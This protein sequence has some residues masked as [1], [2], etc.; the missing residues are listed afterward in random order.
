M[1]KDSSILVR[2]SDEE[3]HFIDE[4]ARLSKMKTSSWMRESLLLMADKVVNKTVEIMVP[5]KTGVPVEVEPVE[6]LVES[7]KVRA[8]DPAGGEVVVEPLPG[9]KVCKKS[10]LGQVPFSP[11]KGEVERVPVVQRNAR[12]HHP[13]CTCLMCAAPPSGKVDAGKTES[14][15]SAPRLAK[16][17]KMY[18]GE[19]V[20]KFGQRAYE[21]RVGDR[22]EWTFEVP[23]FE[24]MP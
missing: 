24:G 7:A 5:A 4:A 1:G 13:A 2:V 21:I 12:K 11:S 10:T 6:G 23:D 14:A 3:K 20:L 17:G 18:T 15:K 22:R 9:V 16:N 8:F 19:S